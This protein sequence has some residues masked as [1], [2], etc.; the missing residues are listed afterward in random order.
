MGDNY[1]PYGACFNCKQQ[2]HWARNCPYPRRDD[3][4]VSGRPITGPAYGATAAR[5]QPLLNPP[6]LAA[7]NPNPYAPSAPPLPTFPPPATTSSQPS[8]P[9]TTTYATS[10]DSIASSSNAIVP[11]Q[12]RQIVQN[13]GPPAWNSWNRGSR[14]Y[15]GEMVALIRE[16]AYDNWEMR[17]LRR[18]ENE[19]RVREEQER[20]VKEAEEKRKEEESKKEAEK[21]ARL[22]KMLDERMKEMEK[23]REE[24]N[25]KNWEK[26]EKGKGTDVAATQED[27]AATNGDNKKR[28]QEEM[29]GAA[30]SQP[31][32][33]RQRVQKVNALDVG[34]LLMNLDNVQRS[35]AQQKKLMEQQQSQQNAMFERMIGLIEKLDAVQR[36]SSS[37]PPPMWIPPAAAAATVPPPQFQPTFQPPPMQAPAAATAVPP[38]QPQ[39]NF[40]PHQ[41][42]SSLPLRPLP[43][44]LQGRRE[45]PPLATPPPPPPPRAATQ[46]SPPP[47]P[48][49]P[50]PPPPPP[51]SSPPPPPPAGRNPSSRRAYRDPA[52]DRQ[53]GTTNRPVT[54][55]MGPRG[56]QAE[57]ILGP[58]QTPAGGRVSG[59]LAD[60]VASV[61]GTAKRM[62]G[63]FSAVRSGTPFVLGF[64]RVREGTRA[65]VANPGPGG[66]RQYQR[67]MERELMQKYKQELIELCNKDKIKYHN[68]KQAVADLTAIRVRDAYGEEEE[69]EEVEVTEEETQE[70]NPS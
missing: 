23:R 15:E 43:L 56:T 30:P 57:D 68:K 41:S 36:A 63:S 11:Y 28:G 69:E 35:Q 25:K 38:P 64:D 66:Q 65:V 2:G 32:T 48:I 12:P 40:Q 54:R 19:R 52:L 31:P 7:P 67:D 51:P 47:S 13:P 1:T 27:K 45:Q 24:E 59:R 60:V 3:G 10:A 8:A 9:P 39:Q 16:I 33:P 53:N 44:S 5:S 18:Q 37:A 21:E 50:P 58:S 26:I 6:H 22:D 17:E 20:V 55:S 61:A 29:A 49:A 62:S 70:E 34:L 4:L 46:L 42:E 14:S